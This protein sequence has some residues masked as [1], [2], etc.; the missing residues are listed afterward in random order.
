MNDVNR[1][2]RAGLAAALVVGLLPSVVACADDWPQWRGPGRDSVWHEQGIVRSFPA[3]GLK[4]AWRRRVGPG[5]SSPVVA[6]GR[7]YL[8]DSELARPK[9]KERIRCFDGTSGKPLWTCAY[10]VS[11]PDWAFTQG[12]GCGPTA[13]PIAEAG[14]VY[15]LGAMG[16]LCCCD[17]RT[18]ELV[19]R[20]RLGEDYR[21]KEFACRASPLIEGGL[22]IVYVGGEPAACLIAFEKD[23]GTEAWRALDE[24]MTNSSP[25]VV[26]AGGKRQLLVWTQSSLTSLDPAT[27]KAYW[28][29]RLASD[30]NSSVATPVVEGNRLLLAGLMMR[31]DAD[32]PGVSLVWP[33]DYRHMVPTLSNTSTP[34]LRGDEVYSAKSS[35]E[36]VCLDARTGRQLW[37]SDKVTDL[38]NGAGIH[39][40]PNGDRVFLYTERGELIVARLTAKGYDELGR[41][42]LLEPTYPFGGRNVAWAPSSYADRCVFAR[43][44]RELVCASLAAK[45]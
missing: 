27:G 45:P 10:D 4:I 36:L 31:L 29:E 2:S 13:T 40:T 33:A 9:A 11:Y 38:K 17:A 12:P 7:V 26:T 15:A 22:L 20:K 32:R 34:M 41:T 42:R 21:V 18:G 23:T 8:T 43:S 37:Q 6:G 35:G 3:A 14:K 30:N 5:Y 25:I 16:D 39:L 1:W 44:D 28:R 24:P 19:W